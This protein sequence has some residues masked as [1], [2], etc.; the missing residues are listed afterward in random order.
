[1]D[2]N[3]TKIFS[4]NNPIKIEIIKQ[5]LENHNINS[6]IFNSQDSSYNMFGSI[7][8]FVEKDKQEKA[9]KL[10]KEKKNE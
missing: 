9:L 6:I 10:I 8:L 5:M 2:N 4:A 1:M 3:W 7:N